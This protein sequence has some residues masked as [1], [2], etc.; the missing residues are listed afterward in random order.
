[1]GSFG[2]DFSRRYIMEEPDLS[3]IEHGMDV[4][5]IEGSKL[6]T[7]ARVYR[8]SNAAVSSAAAATRPGEDIVEVKTGLLG[9]GK[10]YYI[11]MSAVRDV[12]DGGVFLVGGRDEIDLVSWQEKPA[13]LEELT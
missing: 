8:Y 10:H 4:C 7:V 9:L 13:Y 12:T 6:G 11:P 5:D 1:M 3:R 2:P